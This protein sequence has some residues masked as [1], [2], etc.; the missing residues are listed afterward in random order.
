MPSRSKKHREYVKGHYQRNKEIY[1][2]RARAHTDKKKRQY[3]ALI[4]ALR[5]EPCKDCRQR[6]P[7]VCMD[8]DHVRGDKESCV[9]TAA[10]SGSWSLDR[11]LREIEKC[12]VVCS[13][14]HRIRTQQRKLLRAGAPEGTEVS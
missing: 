14:C 6:F 11:L 5:S 4:D 3:R 12:E 1:K 10:H 7:P 2:A 9:T 8:F 13:N